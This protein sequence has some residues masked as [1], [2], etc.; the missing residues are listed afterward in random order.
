V[1]R[2]K[3]GREEEGGVDGGGEGTLWSIA[4]ENSHIMRRGGGLYWP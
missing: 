4:A 1:R 2:K 3:G